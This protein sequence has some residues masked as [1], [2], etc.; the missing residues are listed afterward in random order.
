MAPLSLPPDQRPAV[1]LHV[2]MGKTGTST[3]QAT[4]HRNR[5]RLAKRGILY[6]K[7]P[8]KRR[9]IRLG[10]SMQA[11]DGVPRQS[12]G[13]RRQD[14][15]TPG[16]LRPQFE[17]ALFE[18]LESRPQQVVLSDEALLTASDT[19][20]GNLRDLLDRMASSVRVVAYLRRQDDHLC[21]RY[22]QMV[23]RE[24]EVRMLSERAQA[25]LSHIYDYHARLVAWRDVLRP[26]D[27][28]VR[29]FERSRFADRSL[30]EDFLDASGLELRAENLKEVRSKNESLD[31]E[32]VEFLRLVNLYRAE[33]GERP[34]RDLTNDLV[35][36]LNK[37]PR[38]PTLTLTEPQLEEFM[39]QWEPSNAAVAREFTGNPE[40]PLFGNDRKSRATT[41]EQHLDAARLAHFFEVLELPDE[42]QASLR[43]IAEEQADL[44]PADR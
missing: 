15:S 34:S 23:K 20:I 17:E 40:R 30:L 43:R 36:K 24:G 27:L 7:T 6:P 35:R 14:V 9:H 11:D 2:G 25:D 3:I 21:S 19:G 41:T 26:D 1:V 37:I 5:R 4:F 44:R 42:M 13:W 16:E 12:V 8:G 38:G 22:P 28:V 32:S 10:L 29:T 18:E 39:Q 33:R 31:A